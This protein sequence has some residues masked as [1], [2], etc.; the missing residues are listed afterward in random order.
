MVTLS[1]INKEVG[2][3]IKI[4]GVF[5]VF[6]LIAFTLIRLATI[7]IPKA[8]EKPQKAFGKL[9]QPDFLASQINDKFKFNI[10]TISG[11]LPNL[12]VIA[13]VYKISNPAPNLLALKNFED[14]A[15]NL[16]FKNRTKV[17]NIYYRWSSEEP[18]SRILT[19]NIQSGDFVITSGILKDPNYTSAPLTIGEEITAE[20]SNFLDSLGVLPDDIDNTKTKIDLLSLT[21]GTL[22]KAT[23]IS[24][25]NYL[26]I[27]FSQ[28]DMNNMPIV[29]DQ[30]S[31]MSLIITLP[32]GS[33]IVVG[34]NYSH[35]EV[36]HDSSTYP[37]KTSQEAFDELSNNKAYILFAPATDSVSVK[38]VYLAYYIPKTK[39][40]YLLPVV[41]FE[42]EGFLAYVPGVKDE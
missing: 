11:N 14:S 16:G 38:K 34:A 33:P 9:P 29:Y 18:V 32:Q 2:K 41:V 42:G 27:Q 12:P 24:R 13:R 5:I 25:A 1:S 22:V 17:S 6:L 15:M 36:S 19:L 21:S 3:I 23:S 20:A 35:Q 8:P 4:A 28:K 10:D 26:K 39:A 37:L 40:S 31:P 7:F 30:D